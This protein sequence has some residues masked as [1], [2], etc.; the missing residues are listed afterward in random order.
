MPRFNVNA[1]DGSII[2]VDAPDG[3]T[4]QD[5]IAFAASIYKP[6]APLADRVAQIPGG[7]TPAPTA[8]TSN[9]SVMDVVGG[10]LETPLAL[11][12][13][14]VGGLVRPI[15][16]VVGELSSRAPQGSPEAIAAGQRAMQQ[17]SRGLFTPRTQ[18]GQDIMGG[19]NEAMQYVAGGLPMQPMGALTSTANALAAPAMRQAGT[20]VQQG[21]AA[22][23][24]MVRQATAPI[25]NALTRSPA[26]MAGGGAA[27]TADELLRTE[28]LQRFGIPATLGERTKNLSQ[29]QFESE[30]GRGVI[31]GIPEETKT[32]LAEQFRNFK[33]GQ[34]RDILSQFER[35]T[36]QV[37]GEEG[38]GIDRSSPRA[39]G[40]VVD[41]ALVKLYEDKLKKV[42]DAY[43]AAR[44]SGETKQIVNTNQLESW[45]NDHAPE[46]ISV[47]Q[48]QTI[49]EKFKALK[50]ATNNQ[51]SIDDLENLYKSAG[52][53]AEGN[54][55][56]ALFMGKIKGVINDMTAGAGGDLYRIARRERK[57][58]GKQ[59]EDVARVDQLLSTK[60]GKIDRKVALDDVYNHVI[61]D[62]SLEEM[63][64]VT[65]LLKKTPEGQKAYKELQGYTVQ[66]M[67]D[68]LLK[69]GE[70]GDAILLNNFS[71]FVTQLDRED[72]LSYMFGKKGRDEILDLRNAI[73]DV[74]V[75]EPGAVNY[76]NTSGFVL[77]G[78]EALQSLRVPLA[79]SAAE[80]ARTREVKG[81]VTKALQQPTNQLAPPATPT[82][83]LAP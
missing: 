73:K 55:S 34:K 8:K 29:Q 9:R 77:R 18:T 1:P 15:A 42:D 12:S 70:E 63:R 57:Q 75:K 59:F 38:L 45:L 69:K 67:K 31:A 5:A 65:S 10:V 78:L 81:K 50:K 27:V 11:G 48:I 53:L 72:K 83:N 37:V 7:A 35:M 32:Q 58:L 54:P 25:T 61:V 60:A 24:P 33:A 19:I 74:L 46:A 40:T 22:V 82:N 23:P 36:N 4:E 6:V 30:I 76:S 17:S 49:S 26:Q 66:R 14:V 13:A 80:I 62:G 41:K 21:A 79:K 64:T 71:N 44:D 39:V 51:I 2:P 56:A 16:G 43:Q 28:R 52:N 68:L 47:P 3:A 20:M